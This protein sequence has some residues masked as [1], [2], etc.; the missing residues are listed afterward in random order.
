MWF[1]CSEPEVRSLQ[2]RESALLPR[3]SAPRRGAAARAPAW[4]PPLAVSVSAALLE[5]AVAGLV[6]AV[7]QA[8][9]LRG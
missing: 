9:A 8:P 3:G 4:A 7:E 6:L 5:S 1:K 2:G